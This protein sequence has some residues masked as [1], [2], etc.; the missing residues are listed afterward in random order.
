MIHFLIEQFPIELF[1]RSGS[2]KG[3]STPLDVRIRVTYWYFHTP[4]L[5]VGGLICHRASR[6]NVA[7]QKSKYMIRKCITIPRR[8]AKGRKKES[9]G[10]HGE[11]QGATGSQKE[12][13]WEPTG[14]Q[15][16]TK[17]EPRGSLNEKV[18]S[19]SILRGTRAKHLG[20][21]C[22]TDDNVL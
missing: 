17:T 14:C 7:K 15:K 11:P 5:G 19:Q 22:E 10:S 4:S 21:K 16:G 18:T 1:F 9:K 20:N 6:T 8:A 12:A 3:P 2:L 13:K